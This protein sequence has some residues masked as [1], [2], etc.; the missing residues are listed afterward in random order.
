MSLEVMQIFRTKDD[1]QIISF[2]SFSSLAIWIA[3]VQTSWEK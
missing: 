2:S 1:L 3:K